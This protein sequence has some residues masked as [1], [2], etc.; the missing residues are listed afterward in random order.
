MAPPVFIY[1]GGV[2]IAIGAAY[3]LKQFIYEPYVAP[4]LEKWAQ[5]FIESRRRAKEEQRERRMHAPMMAMR[6]GAPVGTSYDYVR[7]DGEENELRRAGSA[8]AREWSAHNRAEEEAP[9]PIELEKFAAGEKNRLSWSERELPPNMPLPALPNAPGLRK[10]AG[11]SRPTSRPQSFVEITEVPG[12]PVS[13]YIPLTPQ[14][15]HIASP[16]PDFRQTFSAPPALP[17][18]APSQPALLSPPMSATSPPPVQRILSPPQAREYPQPLHGTIEDLTSP[19]V[20][21]SLIHLVV[22]SQPGQAP[23]SVFARSPSPFLQPGTPSL[24][25]RSYQSSPY[26]SRPPSA[27]S[28]VFS[29]PGSALSLPSPLA[30][31]PSWTALSRASSAM[32][33]E[34]EV[35]SQSSRSV[36]D[37]ETGSELGSEIGSVWDTISRRSALSEQYVRM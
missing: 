3:A 31:T 34:D 37:E 28:S 33:G 21:D 24:S 13:A 1:V 4:Q 15:T 20:G 10:R 2:I 9:V 25:H 35:L 14:T 6:S 5:A 18:P 8:K 30:R 22:Q 32:G 29:P 17:A 12:L 36:T 11:G 27:L 16:K 19:L 26:P 7:L 23:E